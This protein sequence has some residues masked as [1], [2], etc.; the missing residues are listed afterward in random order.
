MYKTNAE[1]W[2]DSIMGWVLTILG[3]IVL[4]FVLVIVLIYFTT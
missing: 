2:I 3:L 4:S 1:K